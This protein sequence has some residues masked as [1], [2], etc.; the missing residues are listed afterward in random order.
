LI[1]FAKSCITQPPA[2]TGGF[3]FIEEWHFMADPENLAS[4]VSL[5]GLAFYQ[6]FDQK[7]EPIC[8][9]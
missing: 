3:C 5:K 4:T 7:A 8:L 6:F 1:G 2:K 9:N